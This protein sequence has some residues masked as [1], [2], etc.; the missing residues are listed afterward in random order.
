[1]NHGLGDD[2]TRVF[3]ALTTKAM[4]EINAAMQ[5]H[6]AVARVLDS[7]LK[8]GMALPVA[9]GISEQ[10]AKFLTEVL[11]QDRKS[12]LTLCNRGLLNGSTSLFFVACNLGKMSSGTQ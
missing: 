4:S 1:M 2:P 3:N 12:F 11:W 8:S 5:G 10:D 7:S 9:G 6:I